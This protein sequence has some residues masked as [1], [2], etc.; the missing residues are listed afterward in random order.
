MQHALELVDHVQHP[1][2]GYSEDLLDIWSVVRSQNGRVRIGVLVKEM[3]N[4][5]GEVAK[6]VSQRQNG[7]GRVED[8]PEVE[9]EDVG[10]LL[11]GLEEL[12]EA[13]ALECE[14]HG[15]GE[16]LRSGGGGVF[17]GGEGGMRRFHSMRI[18]HIPGAD[19]RAPEEYYKEYVFE[20]L[21]SCD[22]FI[23]SDLGSWGQLGQL[24]AVGSSLGQFVGAVSSLGAVND[25]HGWK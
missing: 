25:S 14:R 12:T 24:G 19:K 16:L 4:F 2:T 13:E 20:E 18:S 7:R 3:I 8:T 21:G 11:L 17:F 5:L 9:I 23:A 10:E 15:G 22:R 6:G 1:V